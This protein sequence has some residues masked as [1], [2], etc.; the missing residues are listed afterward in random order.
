[1]LLDIRQS[2]SGKTLVV[3]DP[4]GEVHACAEPEELWDALK[5]LLTSPDIPEAQTVPPP[6]EDSAPPP[7]GGGFGAGATDDVAANLTGQA[8]AGILGALQ[9][10]SF[11]SPK[12][13][14]GEK[15]SGD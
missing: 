9:N 2:K 10:M 3:T 8:V 11:R 15:S 1:M 4:N 5:A 6:R 13:R 12:R 14:G 7:Q